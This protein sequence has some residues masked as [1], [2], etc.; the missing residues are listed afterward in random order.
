MY[1]VGLTGGIASGKSTVARRLVEHGAHLIDADVLARRAVERGTPALAAIVEAFGPEM[2]TEHGQL[3]RAKLGAVV[4]HDD[5]ALRRLNAI[6]HPAVAELTRQQLARIEAEDADAV[7]V[8]D[9]PLLVEASIDLGFD[10]IVVTSA[11]K[12]TRLRRLIDERGM[13]PIQAQARVDA[14]ADEADRL[15]VADV[16]IDTDGTL[17]ETVSQADALWLQI[18]DARRQRGQQRA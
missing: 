4:F 7:V 17:A 11:P 2:L 18:V 15:K 3:D 10:L 5:E 16:V 12:H 14:Q 6:T 9:T 8:Y 1:R 13:D